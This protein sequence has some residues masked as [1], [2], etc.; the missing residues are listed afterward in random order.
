MSH[1]RTAVRYGDLRQQVGDLWLPS[2]AA[3]RVPVVVLVHGGFWRAPYTKRLMNRLA[4]DVARR[5]WAAWNL[6]YRRRGW[7][8]VARAWQASVDDV[9][10]GL[11]HVEALEGVDP[12]RVAIC[13]HSAGAQLAF[14]ALAR[15]TSDRTSTVAHEPG[16]RVRA[17]VS[18]AGVLDLVGAADAS[19]GR[20]AVASYLGGTPA[21]VPGRYAE[22][23]P[24]AL[25]P[26]GVSQVVVHGQEDSVVPRAMSERYAKAAEAAGDR[27][28]LELVPGHGHLALIDPRR[29]AWRL[30]A[31]HLGV[32]LGHQQA[33]PASPH[34]RA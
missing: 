19:L 23:S 10:A 29:A 28:A 21:A 17:A 9:A 12:L 11:A 3:T 33:G 24:L 8:G 22:S 4:A 14:A 7:L 32:V 1:R 2:I 18:L 20:G 31:D 26:L 16:V 30:V 15:P 27:V 5:G 34:C 6:E 25:L 13:G